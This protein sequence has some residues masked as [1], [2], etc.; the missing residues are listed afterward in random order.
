MVGFADVLHK[1][2]DDT[3]VVIATLK[4]VREEGTHQCHVRNVLKK[5]SHIGC[6][7]HHSTF[8]RLGRRGEGE[9]RGGGGEGR[10]RRGRGKG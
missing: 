8:R 4:E 1:C 7:K 5:Y 9:E 6:G 3:A 10:G 2:V